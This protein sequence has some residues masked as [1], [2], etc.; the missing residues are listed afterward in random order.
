LCCHG[1]I[2]RGSQQGK[3]RNYH[4]SCPLCIL[5]KIYTVSA[6]KKSEHSLNEKYPSLARH[7]I[8]LFSAIT[9]DDSAEKATSQSEYI[10][11]KKEMRGFN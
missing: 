10:A 1:P 4:F 2:Q 9:H 7:K 6:K 3:C 5:L 8:V 11:D